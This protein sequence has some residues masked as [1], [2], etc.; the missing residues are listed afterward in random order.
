MRVVRI[1]VLLVVFVALLIGARMWLHRGV[2]P[3][4]VSLSW[5][6]PPPAQGITVV[7]YNLY[8]STR[9]GTQYARI[10]T[11]VTSRRYEDWLVDGGRT[12]SYVVTALDQAG[13]ESGYSPEVKVQVP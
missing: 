13:R 1:G 6:T 4:R 3:H 2:R 10:A 7:G 5:Q 12:Y 8:R 11:R 9:S